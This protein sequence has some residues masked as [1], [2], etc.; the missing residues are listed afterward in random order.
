MTSL[1]RRMGLALGALWARTVALPGDI[2]NLGFQGGSGMG[3]MLRS[4]VGQM[5]ARF[6]DSPFLRSPVNRICTDV[7]LV[8]WFLYE[9]VPGGP[10]GPSGQ[11]KVQVTDHPLLKLWNR[12][13]PIMTG[14]Q[15][16]KLT[17]QH[18]ELGGEGFWFLE[19]PPGT[20]EPKALWPIPPHW[21]QE[22]PSAES[23]GYTLAI[24]IGKRGRK[25]FTAWVPESE[26]LWLPELDPAEPYHRGLAAAAA[27]DDQVQQTEWMA[28]FN[29]QFFRGGAHPGMILSTEG[30][31]KP[32]AK[33]RFEKEW[34]EKHT[35]V[36]NAFKL[37]LL[38]GGGKMSLH[39]VGASHKDL[40][41]V[42]GNKLV[43]D[44]QRQ[45]W[46]V[47]GE[48]LG[49][50][51]NSNRA[52][53]QAADY[54]HQKGNV[55]P[56]IIYLEEAAALWLV[57]LW[58]NPRLR[59]CAE[60]P[61]RETEELKLKKASEGLS[62][63]AI[64]VDEWRQ[65]NGWDPLP[66]GQG[67]RIYVPLNMAA[68]DSRTGEPIT[69]PVPGPAAASQAPP[70]AELPEPTS[71]PQRLSLASVMADPDKLARLRRIRQMRRAA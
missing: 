55:L 7:A 10:T 5:L 57:P 54:I 11:A 32:G 37:A 20:L 2:F 33:E 18:I 39:Q 23:P 25:K 66:N 41:Y 17:Q 13:N 16:R 45:N 69:L 6:G 28:K 71:A 15:F 24:P 58:G 51:E 35:G 70:V 14:F 59:L 47:P 21:V 68:L 43:R 50:T 62:R 38:E 63:G 53:A 3:R 30:N 31:L 48:L 19:R 65:A 12:P 34:E 4:T 8:K 9:E 40:D 56:R 27:V 67:Q 49:I 29:N 1:V 26:I 61:V 52:T 36:W 60:N 64:T 42:E 44:I 46:S 22:M